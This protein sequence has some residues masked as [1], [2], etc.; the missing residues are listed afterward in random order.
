M[1]CMVRPGAQINWMTLNGRP[2]PS[3]PFRGPDCTHKQ[4]SPTRKTPM[5]TNSPPKEPIVPEGLMGLLN[6]GLQS[7]PVIRTDIG[8]GF[9]QLEHGSR[10][11]SA[12]LSSFQS[13]GVDRVHLLTF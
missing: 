9:K 10:T 4:F 7:N 6:W 13:F 5:D 1:A 12:L 11:N 2:D 8:V 3:L